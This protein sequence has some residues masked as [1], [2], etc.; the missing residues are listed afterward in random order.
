MQEVHITESASLELSLS[1]WGVCPY[2][3][4]S[5][6]FA[7]LVRPTQYAYSSGHGVRQ[8]FCRQSTAYAPALL[9]LCSILELRACKSLEAITAILGCPVMLPAQEPVERLE[10]AKLSAPQQRILRQA[11][12]HTVSWLREVVNSF[13]AD[14]QGYAGMLPTPSSP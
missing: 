7:T 13:S 4:P 11:L 1:L 8:L 14:A 5:T 10:A 3:W 6:G 9:R 12:W 2:G